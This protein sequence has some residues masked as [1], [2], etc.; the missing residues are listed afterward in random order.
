MPNRG[1]LT[2]DRYPY[3]ESDLYTRFTQWCSSIWV[4]IYNGKYY[5]WQTKEPD[6]FTTIYEGSFLSSFISITWTKVLI[7]LGKINRFSYRKVDFYVN[8]F[9]SR[10][11]R[12]VRFH[13]EIL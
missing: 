11:F 6:Y 4:R 12:N 8:H 13:L 1:W 3:R 10:C 7:I 2:F 9:F 5:I